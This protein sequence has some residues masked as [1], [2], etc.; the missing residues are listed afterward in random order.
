[1][2]TMRNYNAIARE[3]FKEKDTPELVVCRLLPGSPKIKSIPSSEACFTSL[4]P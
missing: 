1:M 3:I 4:H 2:K